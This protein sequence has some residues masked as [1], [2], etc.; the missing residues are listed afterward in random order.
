MGIP[1]KEVKKITGA[2]SSRHNHYITHTIR[3]V[4]EVNGRVRLRT[5]AF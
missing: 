5:T 1:D 2:T 3:I 4:E